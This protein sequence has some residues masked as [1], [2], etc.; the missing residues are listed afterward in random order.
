MLF[1]V[2]SKGFYNR[3]WWLMIA[4][5][6]ARAV[7]MVVGRLHDHWPWLYSTLYLVIESSHIVLLIMEAGRLEPTGA[8]SV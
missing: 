7:H 3:G 5:Q 8:Q 1:H 2:Q 6:S 4:K